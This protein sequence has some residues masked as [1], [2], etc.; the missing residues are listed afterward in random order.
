MVTADDV[1]NVMRS[2]I[3][4]SKAAGTHKIIIDTYNSYPHIAG[5]YKVKYTDDYCDTTIS[6]AFIKLGA[7]DL[8]GGVEVGVERHV[9]LF[10]KAGIWEEDGSVTPEKGWL[11]VYNWGDSTQPNDG[12]A[13]HIG[14]VESVGGGMITTIEGNINGGKGG[15]ATI[16]VGHGNIRGFAKPKYGEAGK[17]TVEPTAKSLDEIAKEVIRGSWGKG[18]DRRARLTAA[19]YDYDA[20]QEK[21][22][23]LMGKPATT[24]QT[25]PQ[26]TDS[27]ML[28]TLIRGA[29]GEQVK[30]MQILLIGR[31]Y[32]CGSWGADGSFGAATHRA[33]NSFQNGNNLP[34]DGICDIAVWR[35]LLG[36]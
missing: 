10:K 9:E 17:P 22:N 23:A 28:P 29:T 32:S 26:T 34:T 7:V 24:P 1:L 20:V 33:L 12:W 25:T 6:A 15:R 16:Q 18:A 31:G 30:A 19:G 14:I 36:V 2:W 11:I 35:K 21:V 3:G 5:G 27:V 13:D 4:L 8:I